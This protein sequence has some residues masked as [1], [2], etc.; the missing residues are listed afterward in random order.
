MKALHEGPYLVFGRPLLL[1]NMPSCFE[2]DDENY[3]TMP[4]WIKLP[5]LP[6]DCWN[7]RALTKIASKIGNPI[8]TDKLTSRKE[9]LA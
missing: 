1:K 9:R 2:F 8:S 4:V 6:L 5:S 3:S 7:P